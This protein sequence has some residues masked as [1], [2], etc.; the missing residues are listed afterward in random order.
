MHRNRRIRS[1]AALIVF[2]AALGEVRADPKRANPNYDGRGNPDADAD[3]SWE[4]WI[5]RVLLAPVYLVNEYVLRRPL[6]A[7]VRHVD[8]TRSS[9][10][11]RS[12][13]LLVPTFAYD[14]GLL[15]TVGVYFANDGA[16]AGNTLQI[17]AAT[18]GEPVVVAS[19]ADRY[20]VDAASS[21]EARIAWSRASDTLFFGIGPDASA[22]ARSRYGLQRLGAAIAVRHDAR[23]VHVEVAP[24]VERVGFFAG[25]CCDD[26]TLDARVAAGELP[27]PPGYGR[28]Y[29]IAGAR[30]ELAIDGGAPSGVFLRLHARP[31]IDISAGRGWIAYGGAIGAAVDLTGHRRVLSAQLALELVDPIG[32]A[33]IPFTEYATLGGDLMP[34]FAPGWLLGRSAAAAQIGYTWPVWLWLD[35]RT[36]IAVG[37]VFD[38]QLAGLAARELRMS[39]DVGVTAHGFDVLIGAGTMPFAH[40][41]DIAWVRVVVG[42]RRTW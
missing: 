35:G 23:A 33:T 29:T 20:A 27:A 4:L 5:A 16:L 15:P 11:G 6:G 41:A 18:W 8:R 39:G 30:V 19:V 36:R 32:G 12:R 2:A 17:H 13:N 1:V 40:G 34:G 31:S 38:E 10:P 25:G 37:N 26:P 28:D 3:D 22:A 7:L 24:G 9:A 42:A 21:V 14:R